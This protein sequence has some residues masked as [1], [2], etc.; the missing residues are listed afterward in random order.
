MTLRIKMRLFLITL[1]IFAPLHAKENE[2]MQTPIKQKIKCNMTIKYKQIPEEVETFQE[3]LKSGMFYGRIRMNSF[4]FD[5]DNEGEDHLALGIGGSL[6]YKS[7]TYKNLSFT[8]GFYLSQNMFHENKKMIPFY[9]AGKDTFS[10]YNLATKGSHT[11]SSFAQNYVLYKKNNYK[12]KV[13]HFFMESTLL[14][15]NDTKM[16][17]NSF[18]GIHLSSWAFPKTKIQTAY[19][20]KQKLRDH[21]FF[22]HVLAYDS[23]QEDSYSQWRENDDGAMH[24]GLTLS[25][26]KIKGIQDR[27]IL[28]E[29][30]N[31]SIKRTTLNVGL[32]SVPNLISTLHLE[33]KY[34]FKINRKFKIKPSLRYLHQFDHGAGE[35]AGSNLRNNTIGYKTPN[36]LASALI[37]TRIDF[38]KG[39]GSLRLG[40][41]K[42]SDKGDLLTPWRSF[43]TAGYTRAMG[44]NNWYANTETFMLRADYDFSKAKL[45]DGFRVM[46]RY[47]KQN[48]DDN[49]PGVSSDSNVLTVD[50]V[51]RYSNHPNFLTKIRTAFIKEDHKIQNQDGSY[52]KNPS[53]NE[54][55]LEMNYLF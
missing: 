24:R 31:K 20:T 40:Y 15:S 49:K 34:T 54:I 53:Y 8:S 6:I 3:F 41:S 10:R 9:R 32:T 22:H 46:S 43:P 50:F 13:G 18:E 14:K 48:F 25:K 45:I 11:L 5:N 27:I 26:L 38:I 37:A 55:R 16:I 12:I 21:E 28:F 4:I 39:A 19:I 30:K 51:K 52:K 36:S 1:F 29:A 33:G 7:A 35:I 17:P 47:S 44:Q 2:K 23:S 42:I